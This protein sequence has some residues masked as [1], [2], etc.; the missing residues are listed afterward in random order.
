MKNRIALAVLFILSVLAFV[1]PG[2][3]AQQH[4]ALV[5]VGDGSSTSRPASDTIDGQF[6]DELIR[7]LN[8]KSYTSS[9]TYA[10]VDSATQSS[11][12]FGIMSVHLGSHVSV[13]TVAALIRHVGARGSHFSE[14]VTGMTRLVSDNGVGQSPQEAVASMLKYLEDPPQPFPSAYEDFFNPNASF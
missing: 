2:A 5:Y 1:V 6:T 9:V 4:P 10:P 11:I 7:V 8:S 13:I 14:Y 12:A 3:Q